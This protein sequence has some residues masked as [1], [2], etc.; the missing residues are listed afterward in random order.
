MEFK[1]TDKKQA[2]TIFQFLEDWHNEIVKYNESPASESHE[3]NLRVAL[4]KF[5]KLVVKAPKN[6]KYSDIFVSSGNKES[7]IEVKMNHSDQL[8]NFRFFYDNGKWQSTYN[9]P[10]DIVADMMNKNPQS[11]KFISD[12]KI[13]SKIKNP[14]IGAG[15][16]KSDQSYISAETL[17]KFFAKRDNQYI[18]KQP[19]SDISGLLEKHLIKGKQEP[20]Y[21]LQAGDDFYMIG[22]KNPLNLPADIP[23]IRKNTGT[24]AVRV[25][26][27]TAGYEIQPEI[28]FDT[29]TLPPSQYS[30]LPGSKK[31]NPFE[32]Y[33]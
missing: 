15:F 2:K 23:R 32:K 28:K 25:G 7:W 26:V 6:T 1:V 17:R 18:I 27:R 19:G 22:N 9:T 4:R 3:E 24:V 8:M 12:L 13:F 30:I 5:K 21:Y 16:N 10:A 11:K 29:K 33:R 14:K 20:A 31:K